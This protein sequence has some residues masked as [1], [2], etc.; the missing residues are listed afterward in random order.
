[1]ITLKWIF[2]MLADLLRF[3]IM[4]RALGMSLAVICL[5]FLGVVILAVKVTAPFIYTLF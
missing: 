5:L 2:R 4:N 1:M 3:G